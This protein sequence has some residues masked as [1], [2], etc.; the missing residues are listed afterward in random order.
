MQIYLKN[1]H[2]AANFSFI[3]SDL[4]GLVLSFFPYIWTHLF[5]NNESVTLICKL[6]LQIVGPFYDFFGLDQALYFASQGAGKMQW[7]V[8]ASLIRFTTIFLG[9]LYLSYINVF[10]VAAIFWLISLSLFL[11]AMVTTIAIWKG[12][13]NKVNTI[14]IK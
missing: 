5:Y 2:L 10:S 7:P 1:I 4:I 9:T 3:I 6:Y 11:Y 14:S 12:A 13:W 8:I